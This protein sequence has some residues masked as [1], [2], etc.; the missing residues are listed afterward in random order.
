MYVLLGILSV[1]AA[2]GLVPS[3]IAVAVIVPLFMETLLIVLLVA[4]VIVPPNVKF[5][6]LVRKLVLLKKLTL[7]VVPSVKLWPLVVQVFRCQ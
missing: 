6:A 7:P 2:A 3:A 5:P 4:A 1:P